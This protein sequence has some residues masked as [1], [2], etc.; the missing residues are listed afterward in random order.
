MSIHEYL[1]TWE[2]I[3]AREA[4]ETPRKMEE[5]FLKYLEKKRWI[6]KFFFERQSL[7]NSGRHVHGDLGGWTW[8]GFVAI[9]LLLNKSQFVI[10]WASQGHGQDPGIWRVWPILGKRLCPISLYQC[11]V[12]FAHKELNHGSVSP[13][14]RTP[15]GQGHSPSTPGCLPAPSSHS[16]GVVC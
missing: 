3:K 10:W 6:S 13:G 7:G 14:L 4:E 1:I 15:G 9:S 11:L 2:F 5:R 12:H 8:G 16:V